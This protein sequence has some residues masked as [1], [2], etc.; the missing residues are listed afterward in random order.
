MS[1]VNLSLL[2]GK[3]TEIN[4]V[5]GSVAAGLFQKNPAVYRSDYELLISANPPDSFTKTNLKMATFQAE[6][7]PDVNGLLLV[8]LFQSGTSVNAAKYAVLYCPPGRIPPEEVGG[9]LVETME[10]LQSLIFNEK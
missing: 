8:P 9:E 5:T 10:A 2:A 1:V 4:N 7:Q 3:I 6:G